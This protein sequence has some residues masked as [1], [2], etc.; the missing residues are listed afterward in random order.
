MRLKAG[1]SLLL[2]TSMRNAPL[3]I[4]SYKHVFLF[5]AHD[6]LGGAFPSRR[7]LFLAPRVSSSWLLL[8]RSLSPLSGRDHTS[9]SA[10]CSPPRAA[11]FSPAP[12]R[13][14]GR[15]PPFPTSAV[16]PL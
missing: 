9:I 7:F 14:G 15:P 12:G 1:H 4:F 6:C 2:L 11:S 16:L 8:P 3:S 13:R 5:C 10:S